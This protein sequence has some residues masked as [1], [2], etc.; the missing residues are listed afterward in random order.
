MLLPNSRFRSGI[1]R[2]IMFSCAL[3]LL[4]NMK[5]PPLQLQSANWGSPKW[6]VSSHKQEIERLRI[7]AP[8]PKL[9]PHHFFI[10]YFLYLSYIYIFLIYII[11]FYF[12]LFCRRFSPPRVSLRWCPPSRTGSSPSV[13]TP[14]P[15]SSPRSPPPRPRRRPSASGRSA[16]TRSWMSRS[17]SCQSPKSPQDFL[18]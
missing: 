9:P 2:R 6:Q 13:S 1:F 7:C 14:S 12:L 5:N 10:I 16:S 15:P 8:I 17:I 4:R 18:T 11:Y 3:V